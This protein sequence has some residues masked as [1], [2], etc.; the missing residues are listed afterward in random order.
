MNKYIGLI[1]PLFA[2]SAFGQGIASHYPNDV[3][4]QNDPDVILYDGFEAYTSPSQLKP[5]WSEIAGLKNLSISTAP[6]TVLAGQKSLEMRLPISSTDVGASIVKLIG[7]QQPVLYVR[8]YEKWDSG[9]NVSTGSGHNGIRM[10]GN[11]PGP[12]IAPPRD[13]TGFF[14]FLIQND[15][16]GVSGELLPGYSKNYAYWPYQ[17]F[18]YGDNWLPD[19]H[20]IPGT[21]GDW[22]KYPAQYPDW[23]PHP[24]WQPLRGVWYCNELMV[25][26]NTVGLHNGEVA[27][28]INGEL[29]GRWPNLFIR[30]RSSLLIDTALLNIYNQHS[31][32]VNKKWY[33]SVVIAK[34]YIGPIHKP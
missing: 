14:L 6:G 13:G 8:T 2:V 9:W 24:D 4:I 16:F 26:L 15:F 32:R 11:Y 19:G 10:S 28:W 29:E 27:F 7:P 18:N 23:R 21:W 25:K 22:V 12:G 3:G 17:R 30:G 1:V 5:K 33:D 31:S 34:K 20:V